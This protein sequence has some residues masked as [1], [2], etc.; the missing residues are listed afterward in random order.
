M[1]LFIIGVV[2]LIIAIASFG[3]ISCL[4]KT[5]KYGQA[6]SYAKEK[7]AGVVAAILAV[8][9]MITPCFA[10]IPTGYTGIMTTFGKVD[11]RTLEAG[12][13][14][15]APWQKIV[16][17][18]NREQKI[19][20]NFPAFSS[21]IQQV[22]VLGSFTFSINQNTAMNLYREVGTNYVD[23]LVN[24][25]VVENV[26]T[27]FSRYNAEELISSREILSGEILTLLVEDLNDKG[28]N[29][30]SIAIEDIDFTD[31]F[32]NAIE[33][34]QVATQNKLKAETEQA[35]KILEAEAEAE[36]KKI[37]ADA[38]AEIRKIEADAIAY[39]TLTKAEAEAEANAKLAESLTPE[40]MKKM[41]YDIWNGELPTY[42]GGDSTTMIQIPDVE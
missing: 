41:Y 13:N 18:D 37:E 33:E 20:F 8:V 30:L 23:I 6:V 28:V 36:R 16:K 25:R 9:L 42:M 35:Q 22:Q 29:I 5:N 1:I 12:L 40:I 7:F 24:P 26:K 17:M 15:K 14:F 39:E 32:T 11:N 27:V 21:D 3:W 34:K 38:A 10:T 31:A 4:P 2:I 19:M